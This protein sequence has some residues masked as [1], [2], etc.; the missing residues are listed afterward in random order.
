MPLCQADEL[1][2]EGPVGCVTD[3]E[4]T[5]LATPGHTGGSTCFSL[6]GEGRL[7]SGDVLFAGNFGRV[8]LPGA[9]PDAMVRSLARLAPRPA[10]TLV[11]PGHGPATTTA[12]ELPSRRGF[13]F[14]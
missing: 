7:S 11:F 8:D 12:G 3:V 10:E 13:R 14:S 2:E 1:L 6:P 9:D 4:I 5:A